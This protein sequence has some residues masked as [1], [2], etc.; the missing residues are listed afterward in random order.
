M[1]EGVGV[2][3]K[4]QA[5]ITNRKSGR[6][7]PNCTSS[8]TRSVGVHR[9]YF[10][11]AEI[12]I[13]LTC[14]LRAVERA[15]GL[16]GTHLRAGSFLVLLGTLRLAVDLWDAGF[17]GGEFWESLLWFV[18]VEGNFVHFGGIDVPA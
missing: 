17:V 8:L 11:A 18:L 5:S 7:S 10:E 1:H 6:I 14:Y 4:P 13:Q 9:K 2:D 15:H 16:M 3:P 12:R